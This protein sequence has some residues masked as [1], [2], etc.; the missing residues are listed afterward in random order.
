M[1]TWF[2]KITKRGYFNVLM[3]ILPHITFATLDKQRGLLG[4]GS[5]RGESKID[6]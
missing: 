4:G 6:Q 5:E 1:S 2:R 3:R